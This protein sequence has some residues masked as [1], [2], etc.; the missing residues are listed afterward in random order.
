MKLERRRRQHTQKYREIIIMFKWNSPIQNQQRI[1]NLMTLNL[2]V[3]SLVL[4][5]I[6]MVM[7]NQMISRIFVN[8]QCNSPN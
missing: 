5:I 2:T 3:N 7:K 4:K 8:T 6:R 1:E